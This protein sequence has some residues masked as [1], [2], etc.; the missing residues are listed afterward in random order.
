MASDQNRR[1]FFATILATLSIHALGRM[2]ALGAP[3]AQLPKLADSISVKYYG[4]DPKEPPMV[5][6]KYWA[7]GGSGLY[8]VLRNNL[9]VVD[10]FWT[11]AHG[12]FLKNNVVDALNISLADGGIRALPAMRTGPTVQLSQ[13]ELG[14]GRLEWAAIKEST[15]D[16][17]RQISQFLG[18]ESPRS[19]DGY[20]FLHEDKV[21]YLYSRNQYD[22]AG[23]PIANSRSWEIKVERYKNKHRIFQARLH[24]TPTKLESIILSYPLELS[25]P[26]TSDAR[27]A[28]LSVQGSHLVGDDGKYQVVEMPY[29]K[30]LKADLLANLS[31]TDTVNLSSQKTEFPASAH[32]YYA[33]IQQLANILHKAIL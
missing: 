29:S 1:E 23:L 28:V 8:L 19:L 15:A 22:D 4:Y 25:G 2:T 9:R 30:E 17:R 33:Q 10:S 18:K 11:E 21:I 31:L 13:Y 32:A 3:A 6:R 27:D 16:L 20:S 5:S 7:D 14:K 26:E 24:G 12:L